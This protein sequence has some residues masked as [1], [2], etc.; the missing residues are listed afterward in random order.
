[1]A[2]VPG[3]PWKCVSRMTS[4][5]PS[6]HTHTLVIVVLNHIPSLVA[7]C[8][9]PAQQNVVQVYTYVLSPLMASR[10]PGANSAAGSRQGSLQGHHGHDLQ[11]QQEEEG[12]ADGQPGNAAAGSAV[13]ERQDQITGWQLQLVMEWCNEVR[14]VCSYCCHIPVLASTSNCIRRV[15]SGFPAL[16]HSCSALQPKVMASSSRP[17]RCIF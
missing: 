5:P 4:L 12:A 3:S 16:T 2:P 10:T 7:A 17:M 6:P 1:M 9:P 13:V 8:L 14:E 15:S 11:Q